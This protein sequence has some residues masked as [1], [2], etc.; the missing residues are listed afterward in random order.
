MGTPFQSRTAVLPCLS[1]KCLFNFWLHCCYVPTDPSPKPRRAPGGPEGSNEELFLNYIPNTV[2]P[3][4]TVNDVHGDSRQELYQHTG[5]NWRGQKAIYFWDL[6]RTRKQRKSYGGED[7][8]GK[9]KNSAP[10]TSS[11]RTPFQVCFYPTCSPHH[12][13]DASPVP[14]PYSPV[15]DSNC[16][17]VRGCRR[18]VSPETEFHHVLA[19]YRSQ[20]AATGRRGCPTV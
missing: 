20:L 11:H 16:A 14:R 3:V 18:S 15:D 17:L 5:T 6:H 1:K 8:G 9:G 19:S 2:N 7:K 13:R 10:T 12:T 4:P